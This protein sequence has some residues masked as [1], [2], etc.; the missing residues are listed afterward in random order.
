MSLHFATMYNSEQVKSQTDIKL[1]MS[2]KDLK[3]KKLF[4]VA[5]IRVPR[6]QLKVNS[7]SNRFE[8]DNNMLEKFPFI[9]NWSLCD[10]LQM[11]HSVD[12][13]CSE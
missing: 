3:L 11:S 4:S 13:K 1:I 6:P 2:I 5:F 8:N 7:S 10:S 12:I 9:A